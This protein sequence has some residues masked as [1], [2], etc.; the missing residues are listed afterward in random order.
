MKNHVEQTVYSFLKKEIKIKNTP[1]LLGLSGGPDSTALFYVLLKLQRWISFSF[2]I[3]HIDHLWRKESTQE[4]QELS[5]LAKK[6]KIPFHLKTLKNQNT[7]GNREALCREE[8]LIFFSQICKTY[9][10]QALLLAHHANDQAETVLKRT[11][12]G[13]SLPQLSGIKKK[14]IVHGITIWRPLLSV[15]KKDLTDWL[16]KH[17]LSAFQDHSNFDPTYLRGKMRTRLIPQLSKTFGKQIQQSLCKIGE[18]AYELKDFLDNR[19]HMH[20]S[21]IKNTIMGAF[22]DFTSLPPL[23]SIELKHLLRKLCSM[24]TLSLNREVLHKLQTLLLQNAANRHII[25]DTNLLF[26]DRKKIFITSKHIPVY[27]HPSIVLTPGTHYLGI[28]EICVTLA[29]SKQRLATTSWEQLW[30]GKIQVSVP[31]DNYSLISPK[32][33]SLYPGNSSICR[34]WNK[35]RVPAF[36]RYYPPLLKKNHKI[37]H[38][39]LTG[40]SCISQDRQ[41]E[42]NY[43]NISLTRKKKKS[44]PFTSLKKK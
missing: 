29:N 28:W 30:H 13:A 9:H 3:A 5:I 39:F 6:Y 15:S 4:A 41:K 8:R 31:K 38:E 37:Y 7:K 16:E 18:E 14:N 44:S 40:K 22:L 35:H 43:L 21:S 32:A 10:C 20:L 19:I 2:H 23:H 36:L 42:Q 34:W 24:N 26:I 12:E 33:N 17:H 1:I 11:F 27:S 25:T